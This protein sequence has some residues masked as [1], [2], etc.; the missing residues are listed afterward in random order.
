MLKLVL[1]LVGLL[2]LLGYGL[3][4]ELRLMR[5]RDGCRTDVERDG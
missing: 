4:A 2:E 5:D 3:A 1:L